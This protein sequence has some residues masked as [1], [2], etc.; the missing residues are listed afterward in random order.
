M[1]PTSTLLLWLL[2]LLSSSSLLIRAFEYFDGD[3]DYPD[4][5]EGEEEEG[6][7]R[8]YG[9]RHPYRHAGLRHQRHHHRHRHLHR[10]SLWPTTRHQRHYGREVSPPPPL[11]SSS[12][13]VDGKSVPNHCWYRGERFNCG[14]SLSCVFAGEKPMD[15]CE[16]G[17]V[18][19]CCVPKARV[20]DEGDDDFDFDVFNSSKRKC[21][22]HADH[23]HFPK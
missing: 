7:H 11:S 2:L 20:S 9:R 21:C 13:V 4:F 18:W 10:E 19:S 16:G 3:V 12:R 23:A 14:L 17:L 5:G 8:S 15:L 1:R 22:T 6:H